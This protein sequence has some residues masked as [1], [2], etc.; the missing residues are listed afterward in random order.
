MDGI[1]HSIRVESN[2]VE[3]AIDVP[4]HLTSGGGP[5]VLVARC[6]FNSHPELGITPSSIPAIRWNPF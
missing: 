4:S 3:A 5:H 1:F 2:S 6:S